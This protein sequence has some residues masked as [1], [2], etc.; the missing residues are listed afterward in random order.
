MLN[1]D[2]P[3]KIFWGE[4]CIKEHADVFLLGKKALLVTGRNSAKKNGAQSDV[5]AVL[6]SLNIDYAIFDQVKSNPDITTVY[7]GAE[8]AK[9]EHADFVIAIGGG[10]PMDA[11]K[12]I[13]LLSCQDIA[14]KDIFSGSYQKKVLPMIHIPTTSGTG[15]E[16]TPYSI[17]SNDQAQTK[18]T[19]ATPLIFPTYALLDSHYQKNLPISITINTALDALSHNIESI[20]SLKINPLITPIAQ[21]GIRQIAECFTAMENN[22]LT[23]KVREKLQYGSLTGGIAIAHTGTNIVHSLGYSLTYFSDI[24]HGRA[25]AL[26]LAE[27]LN[28]IAETAPKKITLLLR[29]MKFDN[30]FQFKAQIDRLLGPKE[31]FSTEILKK[32]TQIAL[33]AKNINTSLRSP[34]EIDVLSLYENSLL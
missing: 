22:N 28:F 27:Y 31:K 30:I 21:S 18:S 29:D 9:S 32:Y 24:D 3:T 33:K 1:F 17:L 8:T 6:N 14:P 15:S 7:Q 20:L 16:V 13:A 11:G 10:S 26:L 2:L 5:E 4:N 25:N 12:A 34:S 19:I 23:E